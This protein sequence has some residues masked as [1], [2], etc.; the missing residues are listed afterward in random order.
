MNNIG[1]YKNFILCMGLTPAIICMLLCCIFTDAAV[2]YICSIASLLHAG[3]WFFFPNDF[4]YN[5]LS[6][7][8]AVSLTLLAIAKAL[9]GEAILPEGSVPLTLEILIFCFSVLYLLTASYYG[10]FFAHFGHLTEMNNY[11]ATM[12]V[13]IASLVHFLILAVLYAFLHPFSDKMLFFLTGLIPPVVYLAAI[14]LNYSYISQCMKEVKS[15]PMLRVAAVCNGKVYVVPVPNDREYWDLPMKDICHGGQD[16]VNETLARIR[17]TYQANLSDK[18]DFRFS[19]KYLFDTP[20][21]SPV[22]IL[23]YILPLKDESDIHFE[24]GRFVSPTEIVEDT[25]KRFC[26]FLKEEAEHLETVVEMWKTFQ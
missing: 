5:T 3:Y 11:W 12:S 17:E 6:L 13:I 15:I 10:K 24:G 26:L 4:E 7:H 21:G 2:L 23:L 19:L 8:T 22:T 20:F 14:R 25:D 1:V 18:P 16:K 9:G